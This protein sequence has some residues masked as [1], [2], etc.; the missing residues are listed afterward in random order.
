[1]T[2]SHATHDV[3]VVGAR[4]AGAAT[5]M[6][7]A[8]RGYNVAAVDQARLPSDTLSTHGLQR[9]AVVQLSRWGL[10]DEVLES[11]APPVRQVLFRVGDKVDVRPF[12]NR[13]GVDLL[14]A[15]RRY[16]LDAI[17]AEAAEKAGAEFRYGVTVT[18]VHRDENGRV[19]GVRGYDKS[20]G[21]VE[22]STRYVVAADGVRSR[23]AK[24]L[25]ARTLENRP[26]DNSTFYAYFRNVEW[27][28]YELH[29]GRRGLA[30]VFPTHHGEG[31][32]WLCSPSSTA[33]KLRAAKEGRGAALVDL[34]GQ[35]TPTLA[36]RLRSGQRTSPVRGA[37]R[38]PNYLRQAYGD[39]WALVGD[40]G[41]HRD[42]ITGHGITDAF[43]DAELLAQALDQALSGESDEQNA[44]SLYQKQRDELLR[45]T[46]DA[47]CELSA[48]PD[49]ARFIELQKRLAGAIDAEAQFLASLPNPPS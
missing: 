21:K 25:K 18:G 9:G 43:R 33:D 16:V 17:L 2:M 23:L 34:I 8:R 27:H 37:I 6:L 48:Y 7:L 36:D 45:E 38:M 35:L 12:R 15:P 39:G 11:G 13:A 4:C 47:T 41:Y 5:A 32:V 31:C 22:L 29:V 24:D 26:T 44:L 30:G 14:V 3:V 28:G 19:D 49:T 20:G 40:A 42:A 1:M 10:L 46:F